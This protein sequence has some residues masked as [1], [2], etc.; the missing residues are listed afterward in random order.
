[1]PTTVNAPQE[2]H[3][4]HTKRHGGLSVG[5]DVSG[6]VLSAGWSKSPLLCLSDLKTG[7]RSNVSLFLAVLGASKMP[8]IM[9]YP[10]KE[11]K[12]WVSGSIDAIEYYGGLPALIAPHTHNSP[13]MPGYLSPSNN[14]AF[15]MFAKFYDI[16]VLP[17]NY[18]NP[19][20]PIIDVFRPADWIRRQ[21]RDKVFYSLDELN[22]HIS[23]LLSQYVTLPTS[24]CRDSRFNIFCIRD[25]PMLRPLPE[26]RFSIIDIA[27]RKVGD[28][29]FIKYGGPYY[30][31]VP[32][33]FCK[34]NVILHVSK[35]EII[36]YDINGVYLASHKRDGN[37]KYVI[38]PSHMPPKHLLFGYPVYDGGKYVEWAEH[39]GS[40]TRSVI[41]CLLATV[42]YEQQAF[43]TC[44]AILQLS[45]KYG[46]DRL[47]SACKV[48]KF[49]GC[50]SFSAIKRLIIRGADS[51]SLSTETS[52][53]NEYDQLRLDT[54]N[55]DKV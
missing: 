17:V 48:A 14:S 42:E 3:P 29:C 19:L 11:Q 27:H 13:K 51:K 1:M 32:Y 28:N 46:N 55:K 18:K 21:L 10:R 20:C 50:I 43:R 30:Y 6:V 26:K 36:I 15:G 4:R 7:V 54:G 52:R 2:C 41:E 38:H 53:Y 8:Y 5:F 23:L 16:P 47:E 40:N 44:M 45:K 34:Q 12:Y 9:A 39:I 35:S 24:V 25:K 22:D 49:Y 33:K 31:S 37:T